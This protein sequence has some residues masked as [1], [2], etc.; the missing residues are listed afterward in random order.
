MAGAKCLL[1]KQIEL[2]GLIIAAAR[3]NLLTTIKKGIHLKKKGA[4]G[5]LL[6]PRIL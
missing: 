2:E 3:S 5:S 6:Y 1:L 4:M